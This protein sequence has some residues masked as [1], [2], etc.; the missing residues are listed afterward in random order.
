MRTS[1]RM[2]LAAGWATALGAVPLAAVYESWG[3]LWY[4]WAAVAAVVTAH[5]LARSLR[6]PFWL[7]P[8]AGLAGLL[9]Y[10]V[11]VFAG[12]RAVL[13]LLPTPEALQALR[14]GVQSGFVDVR[15][16]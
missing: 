16:L 3:W 8:A 5:L 9:E 12:D 4:T 11:V 10:L 14:D 13:G 6:L 15:E 2:T 7:V 1:T